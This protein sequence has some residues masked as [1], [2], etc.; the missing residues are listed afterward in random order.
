M[1]SFKLKALLVLGTMLVSQTGWAYHN[2]FF[3]SAN[4][5]TSGILNPL[6]LDPSSVTMQGN[7]FRGEPL[8]TTL[9]SF[10]ASTQALLLSVS[11][12][13]AKAS[14]LAIDTGT[15]Q[16]LALKQRVYEVLVGTPGMT[17][18]DFN[19]AVDSDIWAPLAALG[20]N[21]LNN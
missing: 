13:S 20:A 4:D 10:A 9:D 11:T 1:K 18:V 6:R 8:S 14:A 5:I 16:S 19:I 17:G 3:R 21:G 12:S 15:L 2:F 7:S